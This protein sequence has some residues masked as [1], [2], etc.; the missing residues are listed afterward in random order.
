MY[1][2]MATKTGGVGGCMKGIDNDKASV[3]DVLL[4]LRFFIVVN[5]LFT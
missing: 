5:N 4:Y 3:E 2:C 1:M